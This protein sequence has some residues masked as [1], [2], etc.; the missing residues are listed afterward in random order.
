[1][2]IVGVE[3]TVIDHEVTTVDGQRACCRNALAVDDST[4]DMEFAD[5]QKCIEQQL[6]L[7]A[8]GDVTILARRIYDTLARAGPSGLSKKQLLVTRTHG[9][10]AN[11]HRSDMPF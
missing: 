4:A 11:G 8:T 1:M 2:G 6:A 10:L 5:C 3:A 9:F 7:L